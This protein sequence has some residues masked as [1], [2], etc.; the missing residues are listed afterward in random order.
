MASSVR[1]VSTWEDFNA[2][3]EPSFDAEL[4]AVVSTLRSDRTIQS[5][6]VNAGV[7]SHPIGGAEVLGFVTYGPTKL[8]TT[9]TPSGT[10]SVLAGHAGLIKRCHFVQDPRCGLYQRKGQTG[11][12]SLSQT[13]IERQ[14]RLEVEM[15][16]R[17]T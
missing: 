8:A 14:Q 5:S 1:S 17:S 3:R 11:P 15:V 10:S 13:E 4:M 2:T 7:L 6:V 16:E 9:A 12:S